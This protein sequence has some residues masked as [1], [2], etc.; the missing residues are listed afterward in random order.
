ML[1]IEEY[2]K[3]FPKYNHISD[4]GLTKHLYNKYGRDQGH[5]FEDYQ[6]AFQGTGSG[7]WT[8]DPQDMGYAEK[9][10]RGGSESA[11]QAVR[12]M[13]NTLVNKPIGAVLQGVDTGLN[14]LGIDTPISEW[15]HQRFVQP[16]D[17]RKQFVEEWKSK[18]RENEG[19]WGTAG[20]NF[21]DAAGSLVPTIAGDVLTGGAMEAAS[22]GQLGAKGAGYLSQVPA[23]ASG[24][25]LRKLLEASQLADQEGQGVLGVIKE[26]FM[27]GAHGVAEGLLMHKIGQLGAPKTSKDL[28]TGLDVQTGGVGLMGRLGAQVPGQ[29]GVAT[30]LGTA[31]TLGH[32]GRLPTLEE[33]AQMAV[34]G[35]AIGGLFAVYP[36]PFEIAS[37][38]GKRVVRNATGKDAVAIRTAIERYGGMDNV[39]DVVENE[40]G[41]GVTITFPDKQTNITFVDKPYQGENVE[42]RESGVAKTTVHQ[43]RPASE[44]RGGKI[45][46]EASTELPGR[47]QFP[48]PSHV[49][50]STGIPS[51]ESGGTIAARRSPWS[52]PT[53]EVWKEGCGAGA[54]AIVPRGKDRGYSKTNPEKERTP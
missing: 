5:T 41:T 14:K 31:E 17:E 4:D 53:G 47:T 50:E 13:A 37:K 54:D 12:D 42:V 36:T 43:G 35:A 27:G 1:K 30:T 44:V 29:A 33:T 20:L 22:L 40:A 25:G 39:V 23:F 45:V 6:A 48:E 32:E 52:P 2:R 11:L 46:D 24:M 21:G 7:A 16:L 18:A 38:R 26:G 28:A 15:W 51:T 19:F 3:K 49:G 34:G 8:H 10:T 9:F